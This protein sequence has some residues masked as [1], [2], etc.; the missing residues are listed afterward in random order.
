MQ[1]VLGN[2]LN[3]GGGLNPDGLA[4]DLQFALD[5]T[6]TA[7]KGPTPVFTR[8]SSATFVGSDGLVQSAAIN[9]P[10]FDH[11]SAG[12][13]RGLLIEES[14]TN[15]ITFSE[16]FTDGS[17]SAFATASAANITST[18]PSGGTTTS[19]LT[20][21]SGTDTGRSRV[22]VLSIPSASYAAT[23]SC[24]V[25]AGNSDFGLVR[26]AFNKAGVGTI[27]ACNANIVFSTGVITKS[28]TSNADFTV[29]S[30]AFPDGW[31]RITISAT[32]NASLTVEDS[33]VLAVGLAFNGTGGSGTFAG[34]ETVL[35]W[36]AQVEA[37]S[38]ATSYIPTTTAPLTRSA[39]VCSITGLAF[40]NMWNASEGSTYVSVIRNTNT[41]S[42]RA[43]SISDGT[44]SNRMEIAR[45]STS[46][47]VSYSV[48][49]SF[50]YNFDVG[51]VAVGVNSRIAQ[52]MK[53]NDF[54][55]S[56]NGSPVATHNSGAMIVVNRMNIGGH[57]ATATN[58]LNGTISSIRY[59]RKRLSNAKLQALTA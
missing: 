50:L 2:M 10:R 30:T 41:G 7:R 26:M 46:E 37:G 23:A 15:Q 3:G 38:F 53:L 8:A 43:I 51:G 20:A 21:N 5:K 40:S 13:C 17:W 27:R 19:R 9:I 32:S 36:G 42:P 54:A 18:N 59:Y 45:G 58:Y 56:A 28:G 33:V 24:F 52:A 55:A 29:T 31:Y 47:Q 16:N 48:G 25:K 35:A 57:A 6:L 39:D 12:V 49:G 14:R 44:T 1:Y 34:T 11:T 22:K 4:L